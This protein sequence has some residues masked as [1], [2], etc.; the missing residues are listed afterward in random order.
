MLAFEVARANRLDWMN[1]RAA[2][3]DQ[4]RLIQFNAMALLAGPGP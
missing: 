2:L 1:I 4:W 3:V